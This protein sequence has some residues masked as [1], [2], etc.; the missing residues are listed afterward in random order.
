M[1]SV[2]RWVA[3]AGFSPFSGVYGGISLYKWVKPKLVHQKIG[4]KNGTIFDLK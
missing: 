1:S 4:I 2:D 3:V